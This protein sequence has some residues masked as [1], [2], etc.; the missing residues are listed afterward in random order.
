MQR[1]VDVPRLSEPSSG[2]DSFFL[3]TMKA[4][5]GSSRPD[6]DG[7]QVE[8][9]DQPAI[10]SQTLTL[11]TTGESKYMP[12]PLSPRKAPSPK[13][14]TEAEEAWRDEA[15]KTPIFVEDLSKDR[16]DSNEQ[17]ISWLDTIDESGSDCASVH[18]VSKD[19]QRTRKHIRGASGET[20]PDFDAAFDAAVEAAYDEGFEPDTEARQKPST[21]HIHKQKES[22]N[23]PS[24]AIK[25][26]LSP[27][28][29]YH[30]TSSTLD[31]DELEELDD[32][33][34]ERLLDEI[35]SD[36]AQGFNFD[37][38]SKSALPRQSDSSGYSRSTWQSSQASANRD[39]TATSLST[40]AEDLLS[41]PMPK[42][43]DT[44]S[45][46]MATKSEQPPPSAPPVTALPRIP[47]TSARPIS[48]VRSRRLSAN[49]KQLKVDTSS[50]P[51]LRKR[52]S[53]FHHSPSP[54]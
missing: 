38:S 36:Y 32:E 45:S 5:E 34:E 49:A 21:T 26:L 30:P 50:K 33:E 18:S 20:D 6:A 4:V 3:R 39:T 15:D 41:S 48:G 37:L 27:T 22:P 53:T 54:R 52:A 44:A 7:V 16:A 17:S 13:L 24:G 25:E 12:A 11:P 10:V 31:F 35:T 2:R 23:V 8:E 40:V 19:G 46:T 43:S 42:P 28:N 1:I 9:A 47:S 14:R 51:D 29:D